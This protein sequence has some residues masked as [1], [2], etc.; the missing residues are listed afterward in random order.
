MAKIINGKDNAG[1]H[2]YISVSKENG[3]ILIFSSE[4]CSNV[5][6]TKKQATELVEA[7]ESCIKE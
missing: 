2:A 3:K 5:V 6:F 4:D 1:N 7:I